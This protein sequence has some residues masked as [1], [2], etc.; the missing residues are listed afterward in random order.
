MQLTCVRYT[1]RRDA[2]GTESAGVGGG[3]AHLGDQSDGGCR[4]S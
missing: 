4:V 2:G 3:A 1:G